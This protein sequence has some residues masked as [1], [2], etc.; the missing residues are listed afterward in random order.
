MEKERDQCSRQYQLEGQSS[1]P[2][3]CKLAACTHKPITTLHKKTHQPFKAAQ[4]NCSLLVWQAAHVLGTFGI[5][6]GSKDGLSTY[7]KRVVRPRGHQYPADTLIPMLALQ[8]C[9]CVC[10]GAGQRLSVSTHH[11]HCIALHCRGG[12]QLS[13]TALAKITVP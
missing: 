3:E 11:L 8:V 7:M 4:G 13:I 2:V 5:R 9:M 10:I 6:L 1:S 12:I